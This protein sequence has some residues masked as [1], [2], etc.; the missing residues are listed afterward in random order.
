MKSL[1]KEFDLGIETKYLWELVAVSLIIDPW[2][3]EEIKKGNELREAQNEKNE[4]DL[5]QE[6]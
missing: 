5:D 4:V 3:E 1:T 2:S 6:W